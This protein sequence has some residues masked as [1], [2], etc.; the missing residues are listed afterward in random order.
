MSSIVMNKEQI[1]VDEL[2]RENARLTVQHEA[3]LQV[4]NELSDR[5]NGL[6]LE[7]EA[8]AAQREAES[9]SCSAMYAKRLVEA[10]HVIEW[11]M[12][13]GDPCKVCA[14]E[15]YMGAGECEPKWTGEDVRE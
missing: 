1:F 8:L 6:S 11:L 15:C 7:C 10:K 3:D 14:V 13:G 9:S 2:I 12:A 5:V 4:I